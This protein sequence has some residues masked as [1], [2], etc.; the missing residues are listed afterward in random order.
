ML[1][2]GQLLR[3]SREKRGW[4]ISKVARMAG[5]DRP[6]VS[7]IES[8]RMT[9]SVETIVAIAKVL[10]VDLNLLKDGLDPAP[11]S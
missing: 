6:M 7:R 5:V 10:D 4:S 8:G 1:S 3:A 2:P 9:G 11:A